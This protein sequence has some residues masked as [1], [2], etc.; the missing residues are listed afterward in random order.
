MTV[1][2]PLRIALRRLLERDPGEIERRAAGF[3]I[4]SPEG[5]R[6]VARL[7]EAFIGGYNAM[8]RLESPGRVAGQGALVDPHFRPFFFEGAAMG[9]LPR[10]YLSRGFSRDSA[11][12][13]LLQMHPG[14]LYL[15]Y[16][17]LGFW[18][19]MRH[20]RRPSSIESLREHLDPMYLPLCYDGFGFKIGFFDYPG[21]HA[22]RGLLD[23]C[24][25]E[26]R[27]AIYQGFGRSLFFVYM[28]DEAS[29]LRERDAERGRHREDMEFG[30]SLALAF[31]GIDRPQTIAAHVAAAR[32][33]GELGARLTG[34]T[35]ALTAREMSDPDYFHRCVARAPEGWGPLLSGFPA[36]CRKA[37]SESTSYAEWQSK[38]RAG[39]AGA[40][41]A[42]GAM[43]GR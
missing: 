13:D 4:A 6:L 41:A 27:A 8:L 17:G 22:A 21:R 35:W 14:F 2:W 32:D 39:V 34:I 24:P 31:T 38:T 37:F 43:A 30:R 36:I 5:R 33:E 12:R 11:E 42:S 15:Y 26:R 1:P 10:G 18:I 3:S 9:Y 40:Y 28:D 16:V 23:R 29:F 19:A 25:A 20:P 7:G